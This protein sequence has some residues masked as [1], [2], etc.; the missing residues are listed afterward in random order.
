MKRILVPINLRSDY[1]NLLKYAES[2]ALRSQAHITFLYVGGRSLRQGERV[3]SYENTPESLEE[4]FMRTRSRKRLYQALSDIAATMEVAQAAFVFKFAAGSSFKAIV[5]EAAESPYDL[6]IMGTHAAPG[7]RGYMRSA[8]AT[9]VLASVSSPVFIVPARSRFN[10]I[11]HITYAVDL[12]DYDP[13]IIRQ[14]KSIASI[15]DAKLTIAHVNAEPAAEEKENY[16]L[17]LEQT[18]SA[19]LDYPKVYY[20]FF[21]HADPFGGIKKFVTL[22]NTNLLAMI[23][24]KKFSWLKIFSDRSMTRKMAKEISVPLLAFSKNELNRAS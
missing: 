21:D 6:I 5:R 20:K 10:E 19:T 7:I 11:Q 16:L 14:V 23:S 15:F 24:R 2:V 17:S 3:L 13:N 12:S 9:K 4:L 18:I 1:Q 22:N 8:V